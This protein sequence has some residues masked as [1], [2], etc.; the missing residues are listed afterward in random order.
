MRLAGGRRGARGGAPLQGVA[1][2]LAWSASEEQAAMTHVVA[3]HGGAEWEIH[4][5]VCMLLQLQ[6]SESM[7]RGVAE[8]KVA[9]PGGSKWG[10]DGSW[11]GALS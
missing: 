4:G 2:N 5:G 11:P 1:K 7:A 10:P 9:P 3:E 6:E 8:S